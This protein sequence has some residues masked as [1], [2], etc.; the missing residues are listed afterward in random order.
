MMRLG[1]IVVAIAS[2]AAI[3]AL[4]FLKPTAFS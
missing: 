2:A 1:G 3:A 4:F